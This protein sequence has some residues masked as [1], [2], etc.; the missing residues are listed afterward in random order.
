MRLDACMQG[1]IQFFRTHGGLILFMSIIGLSLFGT[2][3]IPQSVYTLMSGHTYIS[4]LT[5]TL[6]MFGATV[7]APITLLPTVPLIA[8]ILGPFITALACSVGWTLGAIVAFWIGRHGG[9]PL[10]GRF[11]NLKNLEQFEK[12][13]PRESHFFL[14]FA[15][16]LIFPV[17]LLSYGLGLFSSVSLQTY[18]FASGLG[19][20]WFSFAFS[21]LG[22][23]F[24]S[25]NTVLFVSYGVA[26]LIISGSALWYVRTATR[27]QE[28]KKKSGE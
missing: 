25:K 11:I 10:I 5:L 13:I 28:E 12:R 19:I 8:P 22:Y 16:R 17:D 26:S 27:S 2:I 14:I 15:L 6:L 24:D 18:A 3:E 7:V 23:A 20:L 1:S 4:A 21:Y 9:R